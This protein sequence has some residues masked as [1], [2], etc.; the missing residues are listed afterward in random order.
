MYSLHMKLNGSNFIALSVQPIGFHTTMY[1]DQQIQVNEMEGI[2]I[3]SNS[4][5][6]EAFL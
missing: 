4:L 1:N 3:S 2:Q 6:T 5:T